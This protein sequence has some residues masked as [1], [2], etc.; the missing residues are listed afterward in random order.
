[1]SSIDNVHNPPNTDYVSYS[2]PITVV[3]DHEEELDH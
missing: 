3:E 1:M 2:D